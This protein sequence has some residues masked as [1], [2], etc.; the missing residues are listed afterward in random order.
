MEDARCSGEDGSRSEGVRETAR[1]LRLLSN[2]GS[3]ERV[4]GARFAEAWS[5][6]AGHGP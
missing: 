5:T 6:V 3:V 1:Q 4:V 2:T